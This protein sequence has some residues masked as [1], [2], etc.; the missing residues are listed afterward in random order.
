[1]TDTESI[2]IPTS[3]IYRTEGRRQNSILNHDQYIRICATVA[4]YFYTM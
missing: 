1:M 3:Q 2:D 4:T